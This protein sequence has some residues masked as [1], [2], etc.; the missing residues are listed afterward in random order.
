[1]RKS[2]LFL[3][4]ICLPFF[5]FAEDP[6]KS[7]TNVIKE[8][9]Q[10]ARLK[11]KLTANAIIQYFTGKT[12]FSVSMKN[13]KKTGRWFHAKDGS[14]TGQEDGS[15]ALISGKW[16]VK[17]KLLCTEVD[18]LTC[19]HIKSDGKDGFYRVHS[20]KGKRL[21]HILKLVD[22]NQVTPKSKSDS[23]PKE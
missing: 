19:T 14:F 17:G 23:K 22:G 5:T 18:K 15:S 21:V 1:M 11:K 4:L 8:K 9:H 13:K 7:E 6:I 16:F 2:I 3:V 12:G 20:K 10:K